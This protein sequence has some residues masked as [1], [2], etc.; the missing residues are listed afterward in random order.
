MAGRL[1]AA[2]ISEDEHADL[3]R[4]RQALLDKELAGTIDRSEKN[5]LEYVRWSL[6]RIEDARYGQE[7]DALEETIKRYERFEVSLRDFNTELAKRSEAS[8]Q[9]NK[10][11]RGKMK[12]QKKK[13]R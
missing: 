3:L 11:T 6:D 9:R 8:R 5:K 2:S 4:Q 1:N 12:V 10:R 13:G 7:M